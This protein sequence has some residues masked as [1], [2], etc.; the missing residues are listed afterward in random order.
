MKLHIYLLFLFVLLSLPVFA[1]NF[2][3]GTYLMSPLTQDPGSFLE[4]AHYNTVI[5]DYNAA[6]M[7]L[8]TNQNLNMII[9]DYGDPGSVDNTS[10]RYAT[11]NNYFRYE[12]EYNDKYNV[13]TGAD[14][15]ENKDQFF[16]RF[17]RRYPNGYIDPMPPHLPLAGPNPDAGYSN[18]NPSASNK[19][20]WLCD[21]TSSN[22][23]AE[24]E[25]LGNIKS[26]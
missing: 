3:L 20:E 16:Y 4:Q 23:S 18:N 15:D 1:Q 11:F 9:S 21:E 14:A 22:P 12:A 13:N 8:L 7:D 5:C 24:F 10:L 25:I 2:V 17:Q 26:R 6:Q 19:Y